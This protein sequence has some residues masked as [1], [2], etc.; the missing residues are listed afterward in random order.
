L[1]ATTA[2]RAAVPVRVAAQVAGLAMAN[3]SARRLPRPWQRAGVAVG[4]T[5]AVGV[6]PD[7]R[8]ILRHA[9]Q[10]ASER[11]IL[12]SALH[13]A[14]RGRTLARG[15]DALSAITPTLSELLDAGI[16]DPAV[17]ATVEQSLGRLRAVGVA[18]RASQPLRDQMADEQGALPFFGGHAE[19]VPHREDSPL[20]R[21]GQLDNVPRNLPG[22]VRRLV[23][24]V[25]LVLDEV[26][27]LHNAE[28]ERAVLVFT[29]VA[30]ASLVLTAPLLGRLT[31]APVPMRDTALVGDLAW[32]ALA[33]VSVATAWRAGDIV[34]TAMRDAPEARRARWLLLALEAPLS[35]LA[36]VTTPAWTAA[37]FAAGATNWWQRQTEQLRF[38]WHKLARF[39][40]AV[41]GLQQL[42]LALAGVPV[43]AAA[44]ET[45]VT[46]MAIFVIGSSFGAMLPL[47]VATAF[48]VVVGDGR[49][50]YA[51]AQKARA[52][53]LDCAETLRKTASA[54]EWLTDAPAVRNAATT[55]RHAAL[56]L[57]RVTDALARGEFMASHGLDDLAYEA[58]TRSLVPAYESPGY[59]ELLEA[60]RKAGD[61]LPVAAGDP[62]F[63]PPVLR[64]A[65]LRDQKVARALRA[66]IERALNEAGRHGQ[67]TVRVQFA[68]VDD[69]VELVVANLPRGDPTAGFAQE[70][71]RALADL[72]RKLPNGTR[73]PSRLVP[74]A[75]LGLPGERMWW[76][77]RV[78]WAASSLEE[79]DEISRSGG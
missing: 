23:Q 24:Q 45:L 56:H 53:L 49:R 13:E 29:L 46:L 12:Q 75:E 51:A 67:G 20:N 66:L 43:D 57:E 44:L 30:R 48:N 4:V 31:A 22:G 11:R 40:V 77:M 28:I 21:Y 61:P 72:T 58:T 63:D 32:I 78:A 39:V 70:G 37:V 36:L 26:R 16:P 7:I 52:E 8:A 59:R 3:A 64:D 42:G 60:A 54:L 10:V 55:S 47:S 68:L 6:G 50:S 25:G 71:D 79:L 14:R 35:L 9:R 2:S 76:M 69:R 5:V 18:M 34:D 1:T 62:L 74:A 17:R 65:R 41:V 33:L 27:L 38:D 19:R 73:G 15:H